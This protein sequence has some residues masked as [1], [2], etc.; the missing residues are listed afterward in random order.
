MQVLESPSRSEKGV[1]ERFEVAILSTLVVELL[2]TKFFMS[3]LQVVEREDTIREDN[4]GDDARL[5]VKRL[6]SKLSLL[7]SQG[8]LQD[9]ERRS[10]V[11]RNPCLGGTGSFLL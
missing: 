6:H 3:R 7:Y 10:S 8:S 4:K 5:S 1:I 9:K 2:S 11:T